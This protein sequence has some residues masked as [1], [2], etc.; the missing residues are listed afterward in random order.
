MSNIAKVPEVA[1]TVADVV[2]D[3]IERVEDAAE[4]AIE[5]AEERAEAAEEVAEVMA[6]AAMRDK[7]HTE[8]ETLRTE[9]RQ[10]QEEVARVKTLQETQAAEM[11]EL[12]AEMMASRQSTLLASPELTTEAEVTLPVE[13]TEGVETSEPVSVVVEG[14]PPEVRRRLRRFL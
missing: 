7:L 9:N 11:A 13:T 12:R 10:W 8:I 6:E 5:Q 2:E 1:E 14:V 3:N 4:A